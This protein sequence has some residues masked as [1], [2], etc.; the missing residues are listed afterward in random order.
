MVVDFFLNTPIPVLPSPFQ[1]PATGKSPG[2]PKVIVMSGEN[3]LLVALERV[4]V[5]VFGSKI[6]RVSLLSPSQ[7]PHSGI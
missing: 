5:A 1:S 7:S 4:N 2:I 6:P 3:V